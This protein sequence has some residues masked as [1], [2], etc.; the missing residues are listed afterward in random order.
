MT[1]T[2]EEK[3]EGPWWAPVHP[4]GTGSARLGRVDSDP[5][6]FS[7][8]GSELTLH[9][10]ELSN[11]RFRGAVMASCNLDGRGHLYE[12]PF[13]VLWKARMRDNGN[14][15][16]AWTAF[17]MKSVNE[18]I[19]LTESECE[20]DFIEPVNWEPDGI[21]FTQHVINAGAPCRV[22][23]RSATISASSSA[24]ARARTPRGRRQISGM[25]SGSGTAPRSSGTLFVCSLVRQ[26]TRSSRWRA[27]LRPKKSSNHSG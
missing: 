23:G 11:G 5:P 10:R 7:Q 25:I 6:A 20:M 21:D 1:V 2:D 14:P 26:T 3:G 15:A 12:A 16:G 22:G 19:R 13:A 27:G 24:S 9:L 18:F 17:W 8:S 4:A